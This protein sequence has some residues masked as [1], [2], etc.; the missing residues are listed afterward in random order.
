MIQALQKIK[1]NLKLLLRPV[2]VN[3]FVFFDNNDIRHEN[4][5]DDI[6]YH[7]LRE[8]S[9]RPILIYNRLSLAMR[10][11]L[12][13]YLVIGSTIDMCCTKNTEIWGA[14]IIDEVKLLRIKPLKVYAVR[15]PLTRKKLLEQ[16]VECP[17][18]YGDPALLISRYYKSNIK[19]K[20]SIGFIPHRSNL[21]TI[22]DF[23]VDGAPLSRSND[24]LVIDLTNYD[25]WTDII[26]QICSCENIISSSLHGLIM[27]EAYKIPNVWIEFGKPLI[28]GHF[29]FHDF[30]LSI[31]RDR[32]SPYLIEDFKLTLKELQK[33]LS[34]WEHGII[35]LQPL[36]TAAPFPIKL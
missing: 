7:F 18:V 19:K 4:W 17:E 30:F 36:I 27:A 9:Q 8:I 34:S 29:K 10:L 32:E 25:K 12:K 20:Y 14:G 3:G 26:D 11:K 33:E 31:D 23:T 24:I 1:E 6:N 5:G 22:Q 13:N 28:G 21:E 2:L 35:D 16:G 15:G